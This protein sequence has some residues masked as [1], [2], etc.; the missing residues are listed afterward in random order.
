[1]EPSFW[2]EYGPNR[3]ETLALGVAGGLVVASKVG[4]TLVAGIAVL[5]AVVSY[6]VRRYV[7][8]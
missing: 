3:F 1:M 5:A 6:G 7:K 2:Q 4:T 8:T